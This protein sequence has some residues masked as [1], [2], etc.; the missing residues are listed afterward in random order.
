[1]LPPSRLRGHKGGRRGPGARLRPK[2]PQGAGFMANEARDTA[3]QQQSG[4]LL[5]SH[6]LLCAPQAR[7][8]PAL[9]ERPSNPVNT[10]SGHRFCTLS[11]DPRGPRVCA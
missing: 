1:V 11:A 2:S 3:A 6:D 7:E 5:L 10:P 8:P 4:L 9:I